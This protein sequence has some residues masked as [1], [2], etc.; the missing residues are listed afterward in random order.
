MLYYSRCKCGNKSCPECCI[1]NLYRFDPAKWDK[2]YQKNFAHKQRLPQRQKASIGLCAV[3]GVVERWNPDEI[4][5]IGF[6]WVLD[7]NPKWGHNAVAEKACIE[8]LVKIVDLRETA[9]A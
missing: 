3:F 4:G 2:Y 8:S 9:S 7:G 1:E 6:D 5:L